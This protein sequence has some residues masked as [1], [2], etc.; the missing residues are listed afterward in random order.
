L[1]SDKLR[2]IEPN[3]NIRN[4]YVLGI[5][6]FILL[7]ISISNFANLNL[8]MAVFSSKYLLMNKILGSSKYSV[9]KYFFLEGLIIILATLLFTLLFAIPANSL[10]EQ[11]VGLN[12]LHGNTHFIIF[13]V[14]LFS[15]LS[16]F[17]GM[18]PVLKSAFSLFNLERTEIRCWQLKAE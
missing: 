8:G 17:F 10:I 18:L 5:A 1:N 12:L 13:L 2:E 4:I 11:F 9:S 14:L 7:L 15:L 3:G 16:L 6:A